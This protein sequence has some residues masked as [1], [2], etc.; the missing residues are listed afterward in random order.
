MRG[1]WGGERTVWVQNRCKG[2]VIALHHFLNH[3][4]W[5]PSSERLGWFCLQISDWNDKWFV[6]L[7]VC[8]RTIR[9]LYGTSSKC[10][11]PS[12]AKKDLPWAQTNSERDSSFVGGKTLV[13]KGQLRHFKPTSELVMH[14]LLCC[15]GVECPLLSIIN[16]MATSR[17]SPCSLDSS[18]SVVLVSSETGLLGPA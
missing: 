3:P 6:P 8:L 1:G 4:W 9:K 13:G 18:L 15:F 11:H 17:T 5:L 2:D 10:L 14:F 7:G 12:L 16:G